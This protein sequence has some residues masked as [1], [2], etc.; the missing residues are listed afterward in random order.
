MSADVVTVPCA[1]P[2]REMLNQYFLSHGAN[3]RQGYPVVDEQ[4]QL[5]GIVTKADLLE[6]WMPGL[7]DRADGDAQHHSPIITFDLVGR[8]PI[9]ISPEETCRAAAERIAA[10]GVGR[11]VV[12]SP[13]EPDQ[14]I[15][16]ITSSDLLKPRSRH[17]DDET[18]RERILGA[19]GRRRD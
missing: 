10:F 5:F 7:L 14:A 13:S 8:D 3:K 6:E 17:A 2:V 15:G 1:L 11:L 19:L 4:I 16:I 18:R 12:V 9:T